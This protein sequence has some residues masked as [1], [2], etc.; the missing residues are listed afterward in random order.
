M[1]YTII[2]QHDAND[3][4]PACLAMVAAHYGKRQSIARLREKSGTDRQGTNLAGLIQAAQEVGFEA[5]GVRAT[6]EG[7]TE[8]TLPAIATGPKTGGTT[9]SSCSNKARGALRSA[10]PPLVYA[11]SHPKNSLRTGPGYSYF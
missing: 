10:T 5:R 3:C 8:V 11:S 9:S 7:L 2:H 1:A 4:G 6:P